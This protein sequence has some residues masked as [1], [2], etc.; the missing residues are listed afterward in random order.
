MKLKNSV[1]LQASAAFLAATLLPVMLPAQ[2]AVTGQ[3]AFADY[4][5]QE[6]GVRR[7]ITVDDLPEPKTSESVDNGLTLVSGPQNA[8]PI[9]PAGFK[10]QLY[11]G[12]DA[13]TH[14]QR[15][16]NKSG[17]LKSTSSTAEV[18]VPDLPGHAQLR[19]GG[20]W[21]RHVVFSVDGE[22][23]LISAGSGS[24]ADDPEEKKCTKY[25]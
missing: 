18:I 25:V 10:V 8:W 16:E 12:G 5:Q 11:A 24:N 4:S 1:R 9:A 23:V 15:S 2:Q 19:G 6:P 20:H 7:E 21:T 3:A 13:A 17:D 14:M 22:R